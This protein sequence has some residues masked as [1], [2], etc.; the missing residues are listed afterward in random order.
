MSMWTHISGSIRIDDMSFLS[1][2]RNTAETVKKVIGP[3]CLFEDWN[4]ESTIPRGSE[5]SIEY[6]VWENPSDSAIARFTVS[7]WGDLRDFTTDDVVEIEQWLDKLY[8]SFNAEDN[9]MMF[10]DAVLKIEVEDGTCEILYLDS[11]SE[12]I[13]KVIIHANS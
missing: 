11:D 8:H 13:E 1:P 9:Y 7:L 4:D 10:R 12:K 3:M 2:H 6:D 5:G